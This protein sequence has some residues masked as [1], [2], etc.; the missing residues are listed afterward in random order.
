M[1]V[2]GNSFESLA[3]RITLSE[4]MIGKGTTRLGGEDNVFGANAS[5]V[6]FEE[7]SRPCGETSQIMFST[8]YWHQIEAFDSSNHLTLQIR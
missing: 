2:L 4:I 8:I 3:T 7:R 6:H 1:L 5:V